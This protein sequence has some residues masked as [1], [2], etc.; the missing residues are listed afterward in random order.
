MQEGTIKK[1]FDRRSFLKIGAVTGLASN[2]SLSASSQ[3][4]SAPT[5]KKYVRLGRTELKVSDISFG[6]SQLNPG[7][8]HLVLRAFDRGVNYF[9]TAES[10]TRH[11]SEIV[12]GNA[13]K[14]KRDQVHIA[15]KMFASAS[16]RKSSMMQ[17]LEDSLRRLHTDHV[18]VLFNHAVNR[19]SRMQNDEWYEFTEEA[20]QQG[21]IQ[22]TGISGHAGQLIECV[23]YALDHDLV[24]VLL[25]GHNFGQ[26][27]AFYEKFVKSFD[28]VAKQP[29]LPRVMAKAKKLDV[30]VVAM[31]VLR[32]ARLNDMRPF[33]QGGH[34]YAQAA[35]KWALSSDNVDAA[36]I[37]MT[38]TEKIDEFLGASGKR[39]V[40]REDF[41]LLEQ[42]ARQTDMTYCRHACNDCEGACPYDV[43]IADVLRTRMYA[44]DYGNLSFAKD[45]YA[46]L[47]SSASACLS[48]DGKPCQDACTHGINIAQLCGPTHLMLT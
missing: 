35:F 11:N 18:E 32:G 12:I 16:T 7:E 48:C 42:Y 39:L 20:K 9:D 27:P 14:G 28:M 40:T 43:P 34:T 41:K 36:I 1:T 47:D 3:A 25:L 15:T 13:L 33:E 37:S 30:G 24:D 26:D 21:K 5:V 19:V 31:K 8:E 2:I 6:S 44:T 38:S 22:F 10:Y 29:D 4:S 45:E 17:S 46:Q 23:D